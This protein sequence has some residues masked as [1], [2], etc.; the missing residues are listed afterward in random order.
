MAKTTMFFNRL[1][2]INQT[3]VWKHWSGYLVAPQYQYSLTSEYYAIRNSVSL[4]DTSPLF[5][6][7]IAGAD[8]TRLLQRVLA[9]DISKC[10]VGQAQYTVWCNE[11]G[12]VLQDGVI[13]RTDSTMSS[14]C[15]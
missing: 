5:K 4:L 3:R 1:D 7:R 6:Y 9:R 13:M 2:P 10:S 12:F 14:M 8:A 15:V 11:A